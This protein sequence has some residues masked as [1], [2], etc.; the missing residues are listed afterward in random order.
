[1]HINIPI[2]SVVALI[3]NSSSEIFVSADESTVKAIKKI[4]NDILKAGGSTQTADDLFTF[5][6]DGTDV[7]VTAKLPELASTARTLSNL[8]NIFNIDGE[9][10]G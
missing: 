2:H 9:Y 6:L 1:M 5:E 10:N 3:T 4:T 8:T 7:S